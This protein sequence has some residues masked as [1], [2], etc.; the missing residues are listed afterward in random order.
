MYTFISMHRTRASSSRCAGVAAALL[1]NG[2]IEDT[3]RIV[4]CTLPPP[5]LLAN[6]YIDQ[7]GRHA[8]D[9]RPCAVFSLSL[10]NVPLCSLD[11]RSEF[12]NIVYQSLSPMIYAHAINSPNTF[13]VNIHVVV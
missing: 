7:T 6:R 12:I 5:M 11:P 1:L 8:Q 2:D 4:Q 3:V 9:T 10:S 13:Y